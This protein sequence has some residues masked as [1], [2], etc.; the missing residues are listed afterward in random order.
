[1]EEG[2]PGIGPN[3]LGTNGSYVNNLDEDPVFVETLAWDFNLDLALSPCIDAGDPSMPDPDGTPPEMGCYYYPQTGI[4]TNPLSEVQLYPNP[5]STKI[6]ISNDWQDVSELKIEVFNFL[7]QKV[8]GFKANPSD[9]K[10]IP[11]DIS[12]YPSGSYFCKLTTGSKVHTTKFIK[13]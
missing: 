13:Y 5:A 9:Y 8:D 7:G 11:I 10:D 3:N 4:S 1:V 12:S 6:F 2:K